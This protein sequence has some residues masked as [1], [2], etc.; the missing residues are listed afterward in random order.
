MGGC[1]KDSDKKD[2]KGK[3][4]KDGSNR[5]GTGTLGLESNLQAGFLISDEKKI[6]HVIYSGPRIQSSLDDKLLA[7]HLTH[8]ENLTKTGN[9]DSAAATASGERGILILIA[10][11]AEEAAALVGADPLIKEGYYTSF[12]IEEILKP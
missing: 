8:L 6:Y 2:D 11:S 4:G 3:D 10:S 5:A 12:K 1:A 7:A 9:L